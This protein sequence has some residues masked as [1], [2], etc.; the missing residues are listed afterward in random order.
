MPWGPGKSLI[1]CELTDSRVQLMGAVAGMSGSPLYIGGKFAGALSYGVQAF[2]KVPYAAFTP[3][4]DLA[5]VG[6]RVGDPAPDSGDR[7]SRNQAPI[8]MAS[9]PC[10]RFSR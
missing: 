9:P 6:A 3:A 8:R 10:G 4:A 5:E 7:R 1:L 2:E